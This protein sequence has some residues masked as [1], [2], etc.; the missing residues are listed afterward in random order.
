MK[1]PTL[2]LTTLSLMFAFIVLVAPA[3]AQATRTWVSGVGDDANPC[4]R[5]SPCKTFAGAIAKT[6]VGGEITCLDPAGFG[7][8]T[9]TKAISIICHPTSNGGVLVAG[10]NGITVAAGAT[11]HVV[12]EG[13]DMEG[14]NGTSGPG[15]IGVSVISGFEVDIL[16]CS[17]RDFSQQG[18]NVASSTPNMHVLI[19]NC[20]IANNTAGGVNVQSG[21]V[22]N[23]V[24][25]YNSVLENNGGYQLQANGGNSFAAI[26]ND[27]FAPQNGLSIVSGGQ[28]ISFGVPVSGGGANTGG[29]S[30]VT[31]STNPTSHVPFN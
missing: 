12:L 29:S 7:G 30:V 21:G 16:D 25:V 9:I 20:F 19:H 1:T 5:T 3:H 18:V 8:L 22:I 15:L 17:I 31:G 14:L 2:L 27:V 10:T 23:V 26:A 13:L 11:D 28:V 24:S 6:A 4:S